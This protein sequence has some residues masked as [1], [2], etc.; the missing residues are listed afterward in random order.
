MNFISKK[1]F[2]W[3]FYFL[4]INIFRDGKLIFKDYW[5][6]MKSNLLW[7][8]LWSKDGIGGNIDNYATPF[9]AKAVHN[10]IQVGL[11]LL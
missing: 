9:S 1:V 7:K 4:I 8:C 5:G 11:L 6:G 3:K 10:L 2:I